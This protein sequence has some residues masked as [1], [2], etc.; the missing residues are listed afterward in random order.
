MS[1][2][3]TLL[4]V[5]NENTNIYLSGQELADRL[6]ISRN[7]VWKAMKKLQEQGYIIES[8]AGTGYRPFFRNRCAGEAAR[9]NQRRQILR[10]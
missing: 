1:T 4:E 2:K 8:K 9:Y 10:R 6:G 5:L 3:L 7:S